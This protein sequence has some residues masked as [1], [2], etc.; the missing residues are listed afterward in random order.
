MLCGDPDCING[1][2]VVLPQPATKPVQPSPDFEGDYLSQSFVE[3]LAKGHE[4]RSGW[5]AYIRV[6]AREIVELRKRSP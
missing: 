5:F 4:P 2:N 3:W 1:Y 6:M